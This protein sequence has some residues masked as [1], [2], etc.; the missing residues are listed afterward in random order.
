[1]KKLKCRTLLASGLIVAGAASAQTSDIELL[2][3][4]VQQLQR[5]IQEQNARIAELERAK[6]ITPPAPAV[7]PA[8]P[9]APAEK[10]KSLAQITTE[11]A[12]SG[13]AAHVPYRQTL[14]DEQ[15]AAP[16][17]GDLIMDPKYQG[18]L[19]EYVCKL[20]RAWHVGHTDYED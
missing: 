18:Y 1:M 10:D 5:T 3:A 13:Q 14:K 12:P 6:G 8:V 19:H 7:T 9:T 17:A 4:T 15:E 16:R 2:K 20:C 11:A